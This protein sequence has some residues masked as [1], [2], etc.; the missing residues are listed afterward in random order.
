MQIRTHL[1][2]FVGEWTGS[3]DLHM[4]PGSPVRSSSTTATVALVANGSAIAMTYSWD[5]EGKPHEGILVVINKPDLGDPDMVWIDS[6]HTGGRFQV[7]K[8][9]EPSEGVDAGGAMAALGSYPAPTGPDWGWR[10]VVSADS[11]D[12]LHVTMYNITPDGEEQL[13]VDSRYRRG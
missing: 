3:N 7:F 13:A 5:F 12:V 9:V 10:I 8:G 1:D 2:Q 4:E 6:F 11:P